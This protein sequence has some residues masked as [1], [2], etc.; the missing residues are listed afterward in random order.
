MYLNSITKNLDTYMDNHHFRPEAGT[1]I[2]HKV[3]KE[4]SNVP[5]DN[6]DEVLEKIH[7]SVQ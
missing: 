4:D 5:K 1:M 6:I 3:V 2:A 7:A